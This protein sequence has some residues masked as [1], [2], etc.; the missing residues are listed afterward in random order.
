M[1]GP[2]HQV[3]NTL[4]TLRDL[5]CLNRGNTLK[6]IQLEIPSDAEGP[7][8]G[9]RIFYDPENWPASL[10][11]PQFKDLQTVRFKDLALSPQI[12]HGVASE[13][14]QLGKLHHFDIVFPSES[15]RDR[16]GDKS[17]THL[18][19]YEWL[20]SADSIRSIGCYRFRFRSY[21]RNDEDLPLPSFLASFDNLETLSLDSE[22]YEEAEFATVV[23][24][25][26][27]VTHLKTIYTTS[28]KGAMMDQVRKLAET[29]GV[30]LIWG[31]QP[32]P[33]PVPLDE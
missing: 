1:T 18:K 11:T 22:H 27:K 3:M 29:Q 30:R 15:L 28:V 17:A 32:Q 8:G 4:F 21:P 13:S 2:A 24:A 9:Q 5:T 26:L 23:G 14:L 7:R 25:I 20:R 33:W 16:I 10:L 19:G 31:R 12:A 6:H